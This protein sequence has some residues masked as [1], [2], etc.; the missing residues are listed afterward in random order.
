MKSKRAADRLCWK[1]NQRG[2]KAE[3]QIPKHW[4]LTIV[5]TIHKGRIKE[6]NQE[7]QRGIFLVNTVSK[8]YESVLK[9]KNENIRK[10]VTNASSRKKADINSR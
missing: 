1:E 5:K 2:I 4:K 6:K 3:N 8:I 9:I 7:N 10:D